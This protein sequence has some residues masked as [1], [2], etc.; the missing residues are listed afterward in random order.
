MRNAD[1]KEHVFI[2]TFFRACRINLFLLALKNTKNLL[3]WYSNLSKGAVVLVKPF[4]E[5]GN[6]LGYSAFVVSQVVAY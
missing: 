2:A 4:V 6:H 3:R 5:V 1:L